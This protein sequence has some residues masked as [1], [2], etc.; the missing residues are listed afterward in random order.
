MMGR[1]LAP[2]LRATV[3]DRFVRGDTSHSRQGKGSSGLGLSIVSS[4]A[5]AL[6]GR[7]DVDT[8]CE[9]EGKPGESERP[10]RSSCRRQNYDLHNY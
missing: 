1:E 4:I 8:L 9:G 3:F 10:S 5:E 7:V 2:E 6:G